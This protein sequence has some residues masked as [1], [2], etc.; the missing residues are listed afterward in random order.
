MHCNKRDEIPLL[1]PIVLSLLAN[2]FSTD[3]TGFQF[4]DLASTYTPE[5][6]LAKFLAAGPP[7][8]YIGYIHLP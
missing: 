5:A 3:V 1:L 2:K 4:L 6:E 8:V 7:P